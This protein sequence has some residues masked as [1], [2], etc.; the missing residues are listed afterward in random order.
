MFG[1]ARFAGLSVPSE[2]HRL[3]WADVDWSRKRLTVYAPKTDS[4]RIVPLVPTMFTILQDA[5]D[6]APEGTTQIVSWAVVNA[7]WRLHPCFRL[8][9]LQALQTRFD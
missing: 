7:S 4:T 5:F 2:S 8:R 6:A 9:R 1:L 3:T